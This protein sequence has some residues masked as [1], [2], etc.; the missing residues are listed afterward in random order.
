MQLKKFFYKL[1]EDL[2]AQTP[3]PRRDGARLM[4]ID[5]KKK[6]VSHD[7]FAN[8]GKYL[9]LQSII[10]RNNSKVIPARLLGKKLRSGGKVEIFL[11]KKHADGCYEVL[12][13]P[14]RKIRNGDVI[15]FKGSSLRAKIIDKDAR[16]VAFNKKNILKDLE[17]IGHMPLPPYIRRMDTKNDRTYY[18]TVY[19]RHAGSVASPT[20]GLHFTK[21][22]IKDLKNQ[23]HQF[24]DVTLY[25][26]YATFKPVEEEDIR[27]HKMHYENYSVS[28]KVVDAIEKA[29]SKGEQIISVGTTSCRVLEAVALSGKLEG[30]TN[31]F[32]YPGFRF[33]VVDCLITNFHLPLSTLLMLVYAFGS[34]TLMKKAYQEAIKKNYRFFSYGDGMI[35]L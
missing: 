33:N 19:A 13:K 1:P 28:P 14:T 23:G 20:A 8:I 17:K 32:I 25:V 18:Q 12:L 16:V 9:P 6:K 21:S 3:S 2:I 35:I 11:L 24:L 31:L 26:N 7:I 30:E 29:K 27:N 10:V 5:R 34:T 4:I 22:L 15:A